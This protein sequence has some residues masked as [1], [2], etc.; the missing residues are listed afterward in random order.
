MQTP[1]GF[2]FSFP[3]K[4]YREDKTILAFRFSNACSHFSII[5]NHDTNL[6]LQYPAAF[7]IQY[8]NPKNPK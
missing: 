4:C 1:I 5:S 6:K 3:I 7:S 2:N 8:P